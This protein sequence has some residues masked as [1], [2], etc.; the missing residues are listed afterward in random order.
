MNTEYQTINWNGLT[1]EITLEQDSVTSRIAGEQHISLKVTSPAQA[2]PV[3]HDTFAAS[4]IQSAGG[5]VGFVD[6]MLS[7]RLATHSECWDVV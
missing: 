5:A 4:L 7:A 3:M 2:S 6:V 1:L